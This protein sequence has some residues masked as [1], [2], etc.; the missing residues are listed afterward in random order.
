M[1][2]RIEPIPPQTL[3]YLP[4]LQC[5]LSLMITSCPLEQ[6]KNKKERGKKKNPTHSQSRVRVCVCIYIYIKANIPL[7]GANKISKF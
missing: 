7:G 6:E 1:L 5:S 2:I 3:E 4:K